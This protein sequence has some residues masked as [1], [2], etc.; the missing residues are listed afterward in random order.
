MP[1]RPRRRPKGRRPREG[2]LARSEVAT[3]RL[4]PKLLYSVELAA[5]KQR[6]TISSYLEWAAE[7]SL[8]QIRLTDST[9]SSHSIADEIGQLWDVDEVQRFVNLASRHPELLTHDEQMVWERI[10]DD[11]YVWPRRGGEQP[12]ANLNIRKL[13]ALWDRFVVAAANTE[14]GRSLLPDT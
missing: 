11:P 9:G 14:K 2:R 4:D 13:R 1:I 10:K 3:L 6:R 12:L 5:R 7:R 8:D